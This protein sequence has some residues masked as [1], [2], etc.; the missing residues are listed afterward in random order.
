MVLKL[1]NRYSVYILLLTL[2]CVQTCYLCIKISDFK[3]EFAD[4]LIT[5]NLVNQDF[6]SFI[7]ALGSG[8]NLFP[9]LYFCFGYFLIS[10]CELPKDLLLWVH[11][12][13]LWLCIW[14]SFQVFKN[15]SS[16]IVAA[17]GVIMLMTVKSSLLTQTFYARPYFFYYTATLL[18]LVAVFNLEK[19]YS[20]KNFI[21]LWIYFQ[22]LTLTHYYGFPIGLLICTP[23][24]FYNLSKTSKLKN[25]ILTIT[26]TIIVYLYILPKQLEF[27]FFLGTLPE[28]SFKNLFHIYQLL[29]M[30]AFVILILLI[31]TLGAKLNRYKLPKLNVP[32]PLFTLALSPIAI[33]LILIISFKEG[34][35]YRYF[36][37]CQIG[38]VGLA[39]WISYPSLI[40]KSKR[41][42]SLLLSILALSSISLWAKRNFGSVNT[43]LPSNDIGALDFDKNRFITEDIPFFTSHFPTFLSLI[44]ESNW[45]INTFLL[46]TNEQDFDEL[47]KFNKLFTPVSLENLKDHESFFYHFYYS[48]PHSNIDFITSKWARENNYVITEIQTYPVLLKFDS[49]ID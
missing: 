46:R 5:L 10:F 31:I 19:S 35:Y 4:D 16:D 13:L 26:P 39:L 25:L 38:L 11:V 23:I 30:P 45:Q 21:L 7:Q 36:I 14:L 24:L 18:L 28:V 41:F 9:P 32:W 17:L 29:A 33:G 2:A 40:L 22:L 8:I 47:P 15:F 49:K 37:P 27:N 34:L 43:S 44:N 3:W 48:G 1:F 20:R 6:S 12:P 42:T